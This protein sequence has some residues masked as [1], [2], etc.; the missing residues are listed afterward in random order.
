M[1]HCTQ[2]Q[3]VQGLERESGPEHHVAMRGSAQGSR[4]TAAKKDHGLMDLKAGV[5][6]GG[7]IG[8]LEMV[9]RI[10]EHSSLSYIEIFNTPLVLFANAGINMIFINKCVSPS[11]TDSFYSDT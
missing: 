11:R 6:G 9:K 7:E 5:L 8:G 1:D 10:N 3:G 4:T 2:W